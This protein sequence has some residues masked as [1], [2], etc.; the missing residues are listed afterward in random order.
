MA[1]SLILRVLKNDD[2]E[3]PQSD[4][5]PMSERPGRQKRTN[6]ILDDMILDD[7]DSDSSL[8]WQKVTFLCIA[9]GPKSA[10]KTM[11]L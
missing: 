8:T 10:L 3:L 6:K 9:R 5:E 7:N 4:N 2:D 1:H 11:S